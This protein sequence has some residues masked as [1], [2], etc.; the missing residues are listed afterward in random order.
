[1]SFCPV[2]LMSQLVWYASDYQQP[3]GQRLQAPELAFIRGPGQFEHTQHPSPTQC[4]PRILTQSIPA[5]VA[6]D[7]PCIWSSPLVRVGESSIPS[8]G[9]LRFVDNVNLA[10]SA[11]VTIRTSP[12]MRQVPEPFG[13]GWHTGDGLEGPRLKD[14][15]G[16]MSA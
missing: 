8:H 5:I 6:Q 12:S 9:S 11:P 16:W 7:L 14:V 3:I 13:S 2:K 15:C 10:A 4:L 1:M